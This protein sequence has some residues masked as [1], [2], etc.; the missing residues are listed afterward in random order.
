MIQFNQPPAEKYDIDNLGSCLS[1]IVCSFAFQ[2]PSCSKFIDE[3]QRTL[4]LTQIKAE[5][6]GNAIAFSERV[7]G[8]R[9]ECDRLECIG[10]GSKSGND[11]NKLCQLDM[12]VFK[13]HVLDLG[14]FCF[15]PWGDF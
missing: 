4:P 7:R 15:L 10:C 11:S 14:F 12:G 2:S 6:L 9:T 1:N 8:Q 13:F 5:M 3:G